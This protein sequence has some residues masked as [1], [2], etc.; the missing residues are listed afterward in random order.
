MTDLN[1]EAT[2][3]HLPRSWWMYR[4]N[5][6]V[7][8]LPFFGSFYEVDYNIEN[9][10]K[11]VTAI[12][13]SLSCLNDVTLT[14]CK[15]TSAEEER[16]DEYDSY[17]ANDDVCFLFETDKGIIE[18]SV[19]SKTN[20]ELNIWA[21]DFTFANK[22][23]QEFFSKVPKVELEEDDTVSFAFWRWAG[24]NAKYS[25]KDLKC[26]T[27]KE[28]DNNYCP[29]VNEA[30][31]SLLDM[32]RPDDQGK[33]II[34]HGPPGTGK[35]FLI[36]AL[37][38]EWS[39]KLNATVEIVLDFEKL[40]DNT[41]YMY[42]VLLAEDGERRIRYRANRRR[43]KAKQDEDKPIRLVVIEDGAG[44][45]STN[46]RDYEGFSR[47][48]NLTDGI[49]GQGLRLLFLLTANEKIEHIDD[50]ILRSG[51]CLQEVYFPEFTKKE[52]KLWLAKNN[53]EAKL[54]LQDY[55][56]AD[57]YAI[58]NGTF[59]FKDKKGIGFH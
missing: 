38:R 24:R 2:A 46:C 55:S 56:L 25:L 11:D 10:L 31:V 14:G 54:S 41:E 37:A 57:L 9:P 33:I 17:E 23:A 52:A 36:R 29:S 5:K 19:V 20:V 34:Y 4:V 15:I 30:V 28:I 42:S 51:R 22:F 50:A 53:I 49:V 3:S 48:L 32:P 26:P 40:F 44:L 21:D 1:I 16:Y 7:Q 8:D 45:F 13:K 12:L 58:K 43:R 59:N 35:T 47:F 6:L 18:I 39:E 27:W